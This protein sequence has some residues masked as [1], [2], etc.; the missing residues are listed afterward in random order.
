MST[1]DRPRVIPSYDGSA[2]EPQ[3]RGLLRWLLAWVLR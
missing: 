1:W 3:K 2:W